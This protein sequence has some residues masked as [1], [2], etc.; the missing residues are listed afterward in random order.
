MQE[1]VSLFRQT[2]ESRKIC[3]PEGVITALPFWHLSLH[4]LTSPSET[5]L[6]FL[7]GPGYKH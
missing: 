5:G 6:R 1:I 4:P 2:A 7:E 3:Y